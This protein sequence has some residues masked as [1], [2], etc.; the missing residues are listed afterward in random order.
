MDGSAATKCSAGTASYSFFADLSLAA[1][2]QLTQGESHYP[3]VV[4]S[5][6]CSYPAQLILAIFPPSARTSHSDRS[7]PALFLQFRSCE[8]AGLRTEESLFDLSR[9]RAI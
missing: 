9:S 8:I 1:L 4:G 3:E 2:T 6:N 5:D 7:S